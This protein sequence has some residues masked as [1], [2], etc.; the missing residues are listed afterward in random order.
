[1]TPEHY[2]EYVERRNRP[3]EELS[4]EEKQLRKQKRNERY[5]KARETLKKIIG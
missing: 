4:D 5:K 1:M 3:K 2:K